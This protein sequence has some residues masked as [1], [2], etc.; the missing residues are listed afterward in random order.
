MPIFY[1]DTFDGEEEFVD[2]DGVDCSS[3]SAVRT[4][5]IDALPDMTRELLPDGDR[6]R[7]TVRVRDG[8]GSYIFEASLYFSAFWLDQPGT[9]AEGSHAD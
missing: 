7:M 8:Q 1:F 9:D 3:L 5:A 4:R 2:M 6:R